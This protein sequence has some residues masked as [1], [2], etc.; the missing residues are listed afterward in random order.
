MAKSDNPIDVHRRQQRKKELKKNK[1]SRTKA[2]DAKVAATRSVDEVK[3]EISKFERRSRDA[4]DTKKLERLRKELK[5][6]QAESGKRKA[7]LDQAQLERDKELISAQRTVEGVQK[8]NESKY[9]LIERFASVYY[10]PVLNPFGA[11][12]PGEPRMYWSD[13]SGTA[14]TMAPTLAIVPLRWRQKFDE[15]RGNSADLSYQGSA[16]GARKRRW[17]ERRNDHL[18]QE[19]VFPP[20]PPKPQEMVIL[21]TFST[22][23]FCKLTPIYVY[24]ATSVAKRSSSTSTPKRK[25]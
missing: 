17:D 4:T 9:T 8:L 13:P 14:T 10:D 15:V 21:V 1:G 25:Y 5:I 16:V 19:D 24:L 22:S 12:A 18:S 20:P 7:L 6:V 3:S 2:R 23:L 11:P